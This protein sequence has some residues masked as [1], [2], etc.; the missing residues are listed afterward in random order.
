MT[1]EQPALAT[2][3]SGSRGFILLAILLLPLFFI[4][5][6]TSHSW[7]G[8]FALYILQAKNLV[9]GRPQNATGY[10]FNEQCILPSPQTY[11]MG[12][13]ILLAP[14]YY[15]FGNDILAF[16][17]LISSVLFLLGLTLYYF[18]C[19]HFSPVISGSSV[20]LIVYNPWT[21]SFKGEILA[22]FPFALFIVLALIAYRKGVSGR[23]TFL[24]SVGLGALAAGAMLI[25]SIGITLLFAVLADLALRAAKKWP[26]RGEKGFG[27]GVLNLLAATGAALLLYAG[28]AFILFP[29]AHEPLPYYRSLFDFHEPLKLLAGCLR[30]YIG[31]SQD[32][33]YLTGY[34]MNILAMATIGLVSLLMAVGFIKKCLTCPGMPEWLTAS[35]TF[36]ALAFPTANQGLR[37][38]F[39]M[40]PLYIYYAILGAHSLP[41]GGKTSTRRMLVFIALLCFVH[42][43]LGI[44]HIIRNQGQTAAGPQEIQSLESFRFIRENTPADAV[45]AFRKSTVLPLYTG[46]RSIGN[47]RPEQD[48]QSMAQKFAEAGVSYYLTHLELDDPAL[49]RLLSANRQRIRLIWSNEKFR[50]YKKID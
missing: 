23:R 49:D 12:F 5:V 10:I 20:L 41:H 24:K 47:N 21:L 37:Y 15:F 22:D 35:Y 43:P 31:E 19:M 30:N 46:R 34:G 14:V 38:L 4:N 25:K 2:P 45:I 1:R 28:V 26:D 11:P 29:S 36:A 33:F 48:I 18:F 8:D 42:Y 32:F 17:Y 7:N 39:P 9:E 13:P 3:R 27:K 40:L 50:L 16:S 44:L 6:K